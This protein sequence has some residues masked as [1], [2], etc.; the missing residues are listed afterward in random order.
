MM[1]DRESSVPSS[2]LPLNVHLGFNLPLVWKAWK[3]FCL[4]CSYVVVSGKSSL[5]FL[6]PVPSVL[7]ALLHSMSRLVVKTSDSYA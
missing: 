4:L 7:P 1:D 2:V 3:N 5:G 6:S